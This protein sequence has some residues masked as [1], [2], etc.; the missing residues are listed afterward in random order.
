MTY[1]DAPIELMG[2]TNSSDII[3]YSSSDGSVATISGNILTVVGAGKC[4][5]TA[6][7]DGNNNYYG[8]TS[9]Q[10]ELVVNK[11]KQVITLPEISGKIYG[12]EPFAINA[13]LTSD[14]PISFVSSNASVLSIR[15]SVATIRGAGRVVITT[16]SFS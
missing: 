12:D 9:V 2:T 10:R 7:C 4:T 8:A 11:A 6:S 15:D 14:Q 3:K 16:G 13:E 5:I 1:G